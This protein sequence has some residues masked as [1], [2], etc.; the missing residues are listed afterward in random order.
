MKYYAEV[1]SRSFAIQAEEQDG[2][3]VLKVEGDDRPIRWWRRAG[4]DTYFIAL[5]DRTIG[6]HLSPGDRNHVIARASGTGFPV[7]IEDEREVQLRELGSISGSAESVGEE[8]RA[9]MPGK[10]VDV[11]VQV[12][13][14]VEAGQ[15]VAVLEA[16]KMEND[17]R[18]ASSGKVVQVGAKAG[19]N[20][21]MGTLLIR[22]EP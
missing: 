22:I 13:D 4:D 1:A 3:L 19:E 12:G 20:V 11:T 8:V 9:P 6:I 5:G 18:A 7:R 14:P 21:D 10:V 15:T 16:M 17:I 2:E